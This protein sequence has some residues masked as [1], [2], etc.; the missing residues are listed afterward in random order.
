M[1][2][3]APTRPWPVAEPP[4][5]CRHFRRDHL[6]YLDD[7]LPGDQMRAAQLHVF[8]CDACAAH[9][10]MV[11]RSLMVVRSLPEV[12]P[13]PGFRE[14]VLAEVAM[15]SPCPD[16]LFA[17][18]EGGV[19]GWDGGARPRWRRSAPYLTA[20]VGVVAGA[21]WWQGGASGGWGGTAPAG[22]AE[23]VRVVSR[24]APVAPSMVRLSPRPDS[25][26]TLRPLS[27]ARE[28]LWFAPAG[29]GGALP[30]RALSPSGAATRFPVAVADDLPVSFLPVGART[31]W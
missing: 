26:G 5:D 28:L 25:D 31:G 15:S 30:V 9:D 24:P 18:R 19:T 14:R 16:A 20:L 23:P 13:S 6:E 7:T 3:P 10:A 27:L 17:E 4:V 11:R 21:W 22:G 12:V 29:R 1:R 2:R 8:Q